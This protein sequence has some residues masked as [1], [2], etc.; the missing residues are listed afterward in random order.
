MKMDRK[1]DL[2]HQA[3]LLGGP[4]R[5]RTDEE[6]GDSEEEEEAGSDESGDVEDVDAS[7][8]SSVSS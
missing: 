5:S 8:V 4:S 3:G 2:L 1:I 6:G 7:I